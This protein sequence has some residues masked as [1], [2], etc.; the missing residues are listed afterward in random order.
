[1]WQSCAH[2]G[3]ACLPS[4]FRCPA[5]PRKGIR[6]RVRACRGV[7][8]E[9]EGVDRCFG[10]VVT[11]FT[12]LMRAGLV[13]AYVSDSRKVSSIAALC[14]ECLVRCHPR[15]AASLQ[16]KIWWASTWSAGRSIVVRACAEGD[17][18]VVTVALRESLEFLR[19]STRWLRGAED[20]RC[21][22]GRT[23]CTTS[24]RA[25]CPKTEGA[26]WFWRGLMAG[27]GRPC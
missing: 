5:A 12:Q 8:E 21:W 24:T 9:A 6:A 15:E 3:F 13:M 23:Q 17:S 22:Y 14:E 25:A 10:G 20:R 18:D 19:D 1:M 7:G 4:R 11:D 26:G 27:G 16:G 2:C